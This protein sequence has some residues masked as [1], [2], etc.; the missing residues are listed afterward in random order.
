MIKV[1][2]CTLRG[3]KAALKQIWNETDRTISIQGISE[4]VSSIL[5]CVSD[6]QH[7]CD[8]IQ[9]HLHSLLLEAHV[10]RQRKRLLAVTSQQEHHFISF[11]CLF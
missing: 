5:L 7:H 3:V 9:N 4:G 6:C 8:F 2:G 10:S 11:F 1:Q